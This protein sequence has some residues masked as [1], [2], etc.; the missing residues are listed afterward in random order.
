MPGKPLTLQ[1][2]QTAKA[3]LASGMTYHAIGKQLS[4]DRK[5]IKSELEKAEVVAEVQAIKRELADEFNEMAVR[6]LVSRVAKN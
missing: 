3:L 5:T 6:M 4:R 2:K 1:E